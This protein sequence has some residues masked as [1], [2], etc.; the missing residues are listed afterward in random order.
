MLKSMNLTT[1]PYWG[2]FAVGFCVALM[3]VTA[4]VQMCFGQIYLG[5]A[6]AA[7]VPIILASIVRDLRK[8]EPQPGRK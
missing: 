7:S 1:N 3:L 8:A 6:L 5:A 4:V 2:G